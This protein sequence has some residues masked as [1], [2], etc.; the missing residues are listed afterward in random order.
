MVEIC[1]PSRDWMLGSWASQAPFAFLHAKCFC[2]Q[3]IFLWY[4]A[5]L[6]V[7]VLKKIFRML[8][9][10]SLQLVGIWY[11]RLHRCGFDLDPVGV[12][13]VCFLELR[14]LSPSLLEEQFMKQM[15]VGFSSWIP[16]CWFV[17]CC[18]P[19]TSGHNFVWL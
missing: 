13:I 14:F 2:Y 11:V 10:V 9:T 5:N 3:K 4:L 8:K 1:A 16:E 18:Y 7:G 19:G 6:A 12:W 15:T 17:F